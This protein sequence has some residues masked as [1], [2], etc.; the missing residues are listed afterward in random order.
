MTSGLLKDYDLA[1]GTIRGLYDSRLRLAILDALRD[2]PMR[3]A[4]LGRAVDAKAPNTSSRAKELEEMGLIERAGGNL[5][6]T[7]FGRAALDKMVD[8]IEFYANYEK[9][10]KF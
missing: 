4:D 1:E 2:K 3:L 5:R 6:L 7:G 10:K 9:F 8:S